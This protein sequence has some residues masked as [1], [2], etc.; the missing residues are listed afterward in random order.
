MP[1]SPAYGSGQTWYPPQPPPNLPP[2][3]LLLRAVGGGE[4][5]PA[6]TSLFQGK[7]KDRPLLLQVAQGSSWLSQPRGE[8]SGLGWPGGTCPL[9]SSRAGQ[10]RCCSWR[11]DGQMDRW[12]R[13]SPDHQPAGGKPGAGGQAEGC[14]SP[15]WRAFG[16]QGPLGLLETGA[17]QPKKALLDPSKSRALLRFPFPPETYLPGTCFTAWCFPL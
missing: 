13:G 8:S 5:L 7:G 12:L 17:V 4:P 6:L 11:V 16:S 15:A 2:C 1:G 9:T 3:P 14:E 10:P